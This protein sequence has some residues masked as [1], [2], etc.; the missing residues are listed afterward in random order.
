MCDPRT[1]AL[2]SSRLSPDCRGLSGHIRNLKLPFGISI[3]RAKPLRPFGI[4]DWRLPSSSTHTVQQTPNLRVW[5]RWTDSTCASQ[6]TFTQICSLGSGIH[7]FFLS[8]QRCYFYWWTLAVAGQT[9]LR[10]PFSDPDRSRPTLNPPSDHESCTNLTRL[11][12]AAWFIRHTKAGMSKKVCSQSVEMLLKEMR[13][14]KQK[15]FVLF[16]FLGTISAGSQMCSH[17]SWLTQSW[18]QINQKFII[19][20]QNC[21]LNLL[22]VKCGQNSPTVDMASVKYAQNW[23]VFPCMLMHQAL[24]ASLKKQKQKKKRHF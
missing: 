14:W 13:W 1:G 21:L 23:T 22:A 8:R 19:K 15:W 6:C 7:V 3:W 18:L 12:C 16:V 4:G 5:T 20:H 24:K 17:W 10:T 2:L 11:L 9:E